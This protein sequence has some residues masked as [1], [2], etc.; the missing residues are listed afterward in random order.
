[1]DI[2]AINIQRSRDH[3]IPG[4]NKY[5]EVCG[6]NRAVRFSDFLSEIPEALVEQLQE[7]YRHP[8]DV[9]LFPGLLAETKLRGL[10]LVL[11][12]DASLEC[13]SNN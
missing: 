11:P 7:V 4:Y 10:L 6:L 5:R 1:M 3:G 12:W 13:S 8:D 9:D 2:A